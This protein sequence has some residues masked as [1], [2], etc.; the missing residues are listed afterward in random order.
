MK[1][2]KSRTIQITKALIFKPYCGISSGIF[3]VSVEIHK[4]HETGTVE[5]AVSERTEFKPETMDHVPFKSV[6]IWEKILYNS[7][8]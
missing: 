6:P 2:S 8:K 5:N 4:L 1:P 3:A 7:L